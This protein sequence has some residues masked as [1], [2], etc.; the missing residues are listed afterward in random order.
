[1]VSILEKIKTL[2]ALY[3]QEFEAFYQHVLSYK[4]TKKKREELALKKIV[5]YVKNI[6]YV[7]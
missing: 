6:Q 3:F 1:M 5:A 2:Q 4:S 7:Y